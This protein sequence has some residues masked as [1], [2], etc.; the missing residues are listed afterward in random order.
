MARLPLSVSFGEYKCLGSS[1]LAEVGPFA[2]EEEFKDIYDTFK[3]KY[4]KADH[5]PYAYRLGGRSKS[6]DDGEPGSSAGRPLLSLLDEK[7]ID[8]YVIVARYFGGTKLGI[9]RL[10]RSILEAAEEAIKN[11]KYGSEKT[12][13][14]YPMEIEYSTYDTLHNLAS[15]YGFTLN[16]TE[17][18]IKV[19]TTV[20]S[21]DKLGKVF[22]KYGLD[23]TLLENETTVTVIQ[24]E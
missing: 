5:Y 4:P 11:G 18:G 7:D 24:E 8:G 21:S 15:R 19:K 22:E 17:F 1:F 13:F 2:S 12:L 23:L 6:S 9:P 20:R 14:S 16:D 3:K 10:R